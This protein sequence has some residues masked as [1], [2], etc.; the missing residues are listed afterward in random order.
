MSMF[1]IK[2][3]TKNGNLLKQKETFTVFF[4]M[5]FK[6]NALTKQSHAEYTYRIMHRTGVQDTG[7]V[8][9]MK[10]Q[11]Q[12]IE[13]MTIR[14][15]LN[16]VHILGKLTKSSGINPDFVLFISPDLDGKINK[17]WQFLNDCLDHNVK[18][19]T[20]RNKWTKNTCTDFKIVRE[21]LML[22]RDFADLNPNTKFMNIDPNYDKVK[23]Q[24]SITVCDALNDR[25]N[26]QL[27]LLPA[28]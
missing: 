16:C 13:H 25:L 10:D 26:R 8:Y 28:V 15:L 27:Q 7:T 23:Y 4:K 5:K 11:V 17:S 24:K 18:K 21:E 3:K 9:K 2:L 14:V 22:L 6:H 12:S 1:S 20:F 19:A